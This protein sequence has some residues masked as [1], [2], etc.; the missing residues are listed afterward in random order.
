[1]NAGIQQFLLHDLTMAHISEHDHSRNGNKNRQYKL[2]SD[3]MLPVEQVQER[4]EHDIG[5][6]QV[7]DT[8]QYFMA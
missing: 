8:Q 6:T 2:E 7:T 5:H 4:E 3:H 1:M